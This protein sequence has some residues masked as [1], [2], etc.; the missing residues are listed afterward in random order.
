MEA[1]KSKVRYYRHNDM[2][3]LE[4]LLLAQDVEDKKNPKA[5]KVTRKF[6][7][8]EGIYMNTGQ[9]CPLPRLIEFKVMCQWCLILIR[10]FMAIQ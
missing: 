2:D 1:S 6:I 10:S 3:H 8:A 9:I 4:S 5:A 7:V